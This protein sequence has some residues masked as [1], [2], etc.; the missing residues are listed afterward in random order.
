[1]PTI[2]RPTL[3]HCWPAGPATGRVCISN[4]TRLRRREV[5]SD[6]RAC[7]VRVAQG[8]PTRP[9]DDRLPSSP[10]SAAEHGDRD[11]QWSKTSTRQ[12]TTSRSD[13]DSPAPA[14]TRCL[15][16][17]RHAMPQGSTLAAQRTSF[18]S[19][20]MC[21]QGARRGAEQTKSGSPACRLATRQGPLSHGQDADPELRPQSPRNPTAPRRPDQLDDAVA[22]CSPWR[23]FS[24][25]PSGVLHRD[26]YWARCPA[27]CRIEISPFMAKT[28]SVFEWTTPSL[29]V[30]LSFTW[31][32]PGKDAPNT[33]KK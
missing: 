7:G 1:M 3:S 31:H 17:L 11:R 2:E 12:V 22:S 19:S 33:S 26:L 4:P 32:Q 23:W 20:A 6:S 16:S 8:R 14:E 18:V 13:S 9:G 5:P 27:C 28:V 15:A 21:Q 25:K 24:S 29:N 10:R 30:K